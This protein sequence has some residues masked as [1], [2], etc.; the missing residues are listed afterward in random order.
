MSA[1][2][3]ERTAWAVIDANRYMTLGTVDADGRPRVTPVF[4][5]A[6]DHRELV[7]VSDPRSVHSRNLAARPHVAIVIFDSTIPLETEGYGVYVTATADRPAGEARD[8]ALEALVRRSEAHG[9]RRW[10][11]ELVEP[12]ARMRVYR[13]VAH[14]LDVWPEVGTWDR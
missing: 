1:E 12:P 3:T 9:G 11:P 8:R 2:R 7:W 14:A 5:A 10:T 13:A 4:F 6:V